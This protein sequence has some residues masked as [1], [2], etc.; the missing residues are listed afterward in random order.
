MT[1]SESVEASGGHAH[2]AGRPSGKFLVDGAAVETARVTTDEQGRASVQYRTSGVAGEE[3][4]Q[5]R[6]VSGG[7]DPTTSSVIIRLEGLMELPDGPGIDKIGETGSHPGNH[8]GTPEAN[9]SILR[10][11]ERGVHRTV[12]TSEG[13]RSTLASR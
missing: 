1:S 7:L 6:D 9:A 5:A 12:P 10:I 3:I 8:F 13:H 2:H 4:I 11:A